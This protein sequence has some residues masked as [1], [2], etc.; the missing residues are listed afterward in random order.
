ML[1]RCARFQQG[2]LGKSCAGL[3]WLRPD[4]RN[5]FDIWQMWLQ[6]ARELFELVRIVARKNDLHEL[7]TDERHRLMRGEVFASSNG[8]VEQGV[9]LF[10]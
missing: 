7:V 8:E 4:V 9:E 6:D 10:T 5:E 1:T 2:V 3:S